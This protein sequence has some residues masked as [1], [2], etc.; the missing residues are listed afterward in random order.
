MSP[1]VPNRAPGLE[2]TAPRSHRGQQ[3][4]PL[5]PSGCLRFGTS[6]PGSR[7]APTG[8]HR[9]A[10][11]SQ[12]RS[13]A[14]LVLRSDGAALLRAVRFCR[15][16]M[17]P[18]GPSTAHLPHRAHPRLHSAALILFFFSPSRLSLLL[19]C[20]YQKSSP[21]L[22]G[23]SFSLIPLSRGGGRTPTPGGTPH[24]CGV[25]SLRSRI[26]TSG[27]PGALRTLRSV[28]GGGAPPRTCPRPRRPAPRPVCRC[29]P[30]PPRCRPVPSARTFA[31]GRARVV[32]GHVN[33]RVGPLGRYRTGAGMER[34]KVFVALDVLCV[35]VGESPLGAAGPLPPRWGGGGLGADGV[36][37]GRSGR[38]LR[39]QRDRSPEGHL[40]DR[41][42]PTGKRSAFAPPGTERYDPV[43]PL[44]PYGA[45]RRG[46]PEH[47]PTGPLR[48]RAAAA[49]P[50]HGD[51]D[52]WPSG[53]RALC[54]PRGS[55][56]PDARF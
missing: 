45:P 12:L 8:K 56:R 46:H 55:L 50:G 17:R 43:R 29:R 23:F 26:N 13:N 33:H 20:C 28:L 4:R 6:R 40:R 47:R 27:A 2:Q 7:S 31:P 35:V 3:L 36:P 32:P 5:L 19:Y 34:R 16:P 22:S 38:A 25:P 49:G 21:G 10:F 39:W 24:S 54:P 37:S 44:C 42:T 9:D 52:G 11:E 51:G 15:T 48:P 30:V 18:I 53:P 1:S 41:G 14:R